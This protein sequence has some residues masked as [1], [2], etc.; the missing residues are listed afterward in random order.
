MGLS[1]EDAILSPNGMLTKMFRDMYF[2]NGKPSITV[3]METVENNQENMTE[4]VANIEKLLNK[5]MWLLIT[6]LLGSLGTI[7][8]EVFKMVVK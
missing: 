1:Q 3:R 2:G 7:A 8:L 6:T 4:R 5:A